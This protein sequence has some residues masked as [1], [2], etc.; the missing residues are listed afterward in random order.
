MSNFCTGS[1]GFI[2]S[3]LVQKIGGEVYDNYSV[4]NSI[5][6]SGA[7]KR[8]ILDFQ[9][10][11]SAMRTHDMVWHLAASGDIS[12]GMKNTLQDLNN[13]TLGT[14]NVLEAMRLNGIK[15]I[16]FS[17]S[18]TFY[19]NQEGLMTEENKPA[20]ISLYGASKVAGEQLISAYSH[21]FGINAWI[22]RF[23]NVIGGRMGRGVIYDF[24][25]K[26][27]KNPE[28]LEIIGD[29][30]QTKPYF[31]VEDCIDGMIC[32]TRF[33]PDTYNLAPM[34]YT[35]VDEIAYIVADEMGI[36]NVKLIHTESPKYDAPV[37]RLDSTKI[38]KLGWQ[39]S[40]TSS[41]AVMIATRRLLGK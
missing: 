34:T 13:N 8:D 5:L 11:K 12:V 30:K 18:A 9:K 27:K 36:K 2:G 39:P 16:V 21:L 40:H 15:K 28:E 7:E 32:G 31:L 19:G 20:A 25:N 22:F 29:G 3:H 10:L 23:G 41:E 6:T 1:A 14:R 35:T 24:I 17:S 38:Q 26:L 37:V 33:P 4:P